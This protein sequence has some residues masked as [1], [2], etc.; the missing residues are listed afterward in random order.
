M[1][2]NTIKEARE[3][4]GISQRRMSDLLGIPVRTIENWDSGSRQP[5]E[6]VKNLVIDKL[7]EL[8]NKGVI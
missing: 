7:I 8:K 2:F 6:W 3:Y 4:V 5:T 1:N